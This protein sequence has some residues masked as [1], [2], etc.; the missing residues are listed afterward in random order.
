[1]SK[2]E[3]IVFCHWQVHVFQK[4]DYLTLRDIS[5][6]KFNG[7]SQAATNCGFVP[8]CHLVCA[9]VARHIR[10]LLSCVH[11]HCASVAIG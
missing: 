6:L 4:D 1:M 11:P 9:L 7:K 10:T 3:V 5:F 8:P 2:L